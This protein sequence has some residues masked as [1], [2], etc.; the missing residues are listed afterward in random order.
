MVT[1]TSLQA[2]NNFGEMIDT[3][4]REPVVITRRGRPVSIVISPNSDPL[5]LQYEFRR[6]VSQLYPLRGKEAVET[7]SAVTAPV[8]ARAEADGL[9]QEKLNRLLDE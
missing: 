5:K 9:T 2:Q 7:L 3:S 1:M 6:L 8:R 4:Q